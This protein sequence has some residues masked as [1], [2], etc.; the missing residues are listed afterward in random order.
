MCLFIVPTPRIL[1]AI[2]SIQVVHS[3]IYIAEY[4]SR[5]QGFVSTILLMSAVPGKALVSHYRL[6][7]LG[8]I[9]IW[10]PL[11]LYSLS[12]AWLNKVHTLRGVIFLVNLGLPKTQYAWFRPRC[13][14]SLVSSITEPP[15]PSRLLSH[16]CTCPFFSS[17][18][19]H[20]S[21]NSPYHVCIYNYLDWI[22]RQDSKQ[23]PYIQY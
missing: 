22:P 1:F 5:T 8:K 7:G 16:S 20:P 3:S 10:R 13:V 21:V 9:I 12:W 23:R 19:P 17:Y 15:L 18:I 11:H 2:L 14:R 6:C 4:K